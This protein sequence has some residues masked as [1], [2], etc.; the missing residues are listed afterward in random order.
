MNLVVSSKHPL[1][2]TEKWVREKFESVVNKD[3]VI[4]DLSQPAP[5]PEGSQGRMIKYIPVKDEDTISFQWVL[6]YYEMELNSKP[7]EYYSHLFGHEGEN[8]LLSYLKEQGLALELSAGGDH[9]MS[10]FSNFLV[11]VQLTKKGLENVESVVEAVFQY[12]QKLRELGP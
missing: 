1:D 12:A 9:E 5:Y 4:P 7:L 2:D 6:P 8:S 11:E 10:S 3:V